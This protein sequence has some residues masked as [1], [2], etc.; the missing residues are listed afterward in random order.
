M[1]TQ[2]QMQVKTHV[3]DAGGNGYPVVITRNSRNIR[4]FEGNRRTKSFKST[5]VNETEARKLFTQFWFASY[6]D[7]F[8]N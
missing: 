6:A 7:E 3:L 1:Q 2:S 4:V 5:L 8:L